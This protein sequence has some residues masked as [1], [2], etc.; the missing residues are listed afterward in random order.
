MQKQ[1]R[2]PDAGF[3]S[4]EDERAADKPSSENTIELG[5]TGRHALFGGGSDLAQAH[6]PDGPGHV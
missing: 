4:E 3:P 6:R 5:Q 1:R 2:L